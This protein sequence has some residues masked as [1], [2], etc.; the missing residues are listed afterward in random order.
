MAYFATTYQYIDDAGKVSAVRPEHREYLA[1][2]TEQGH[3]AVSGPYVSG[4]A[5][6]MLVFVADS[7]ARARELIDGDP[8]VR[9]GLVA[10]LGV[11]E[12]TPVSGALLD[13]F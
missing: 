2:L 10:E 9:D 6:A 13:Q 8:F 1:D 11:Q 7:E 12:W 5:G 4:P 3:L